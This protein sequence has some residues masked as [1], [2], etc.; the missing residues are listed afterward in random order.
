MPSD[1]HTA[2]RAVGA[3]M[4]T[5]ASLA[6]AACGG[7]SDNGGAQAASGDNGGTVSVQSAGRVG[8]VLTSAGMTLYTPDQESKGKILCTGACESFWT[9][10]EPAGGMPPVA[11]GNTGKLAVI[12]RPDGTRQVTAD[13]RP[14]YTFSEDSAGDT[15][16]NG[17]TDAFGGHHF[18]WHAVLAGGKVASSASGG[19]SSGGGG[20]YSGGGY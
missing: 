20:A 7:G 6:L 18:T 10:L 17:F 13:G 16:G 5:G 15:K 8:D 14:L 2:V 19:S 9:P 12:R 1:T 11:D 3:V 4:L